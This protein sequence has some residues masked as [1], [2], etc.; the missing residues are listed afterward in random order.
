M[1]LL[2]KYMRL[3]KMQSFKRVV[4]TGMG[5]IAPGSKG[6]AEYFKYLT[7]GKGF[8]NTVSRFDSKIFST[9]ICAE[10]EN[11]ESKIKELNDE[12]KRQD[13]SAQYA[14]LASL[15]AVKQSNLKDNQFDIYLG[16]TTAG[17][18]SVESGFDLARKN[19]KIPDHFW[20]LWLPATALETVKKRF[21]VKKFGQLFSTGCA[22]GSDS[23]GAAFEAIKSG[24]EKTILCVATEAPLTPL[25]FVSFCAMG[26]FSKRNDDPVHAS[27]PFDARR[28]GFVLSEGAAALVLEEYQHAINRGAKILGEIIGY[29][30]T[31]SAY[32]MNRP[33][34]EGAESARAM[35][36]AIEEAQ[37]KPEQIGY[38]AYHGSSTQLN[39]KSETNAVKKAFGRAAYQVPGSSIKSMIGHPLG[40]AGAMQ[41]VA[42]LMALEHGILPPT[43]NYEFPDPDCDLDYIPNVARKKE[44][45]YA[46]VNSS[47]F[48]G[49][50]S[51]LIFKK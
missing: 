33:D 7:M 6:V 40:P 22:S 41:S 4:V 20:D 39:E 12:E 3:K 49:K 27:R 23:I 26:A 15:E 21:S 9:H 29:G 34:P 1:I 28:D 17:F 14:V 10:I 38:I 36:M 45:E 35:K 31:L 2:K 11:F 42:A 5:I 16:I 48:G 47:G 50:N 44:I 8:V 13:R 46:M 18:D 30:T 24:N 25:V 37:I 32:H 19:K 43:I 51:T